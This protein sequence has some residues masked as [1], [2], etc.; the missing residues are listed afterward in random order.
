MEGKKRGKVDCA[1]CSILLKSRMHQVD[2]TCRTRT[3]VLC[4]RGRIMRC[5]RCPNQV[6]AA[7]GIAGTRA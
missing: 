3:H 1:F 4:A 6:V 5:W 2:T 7:K